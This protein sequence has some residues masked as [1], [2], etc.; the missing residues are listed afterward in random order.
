MPKVTLNRL[1]TLSPS[2]IGS[3]NTNSE[4]LETALEN[5]LSRDG[6]TPNEMEADLD[7]NSN[8]ILNARAIITEAVGATLIET[9]RCYVNEIAIHDLI[10]DTTDLEN[11][12]TALEEW[13]DEEEGRGVS[14]D[15]RIDDLES[16]QT[17][18]N[19]HLLSLDAADVSHEAS[20]ASLNSGQTTQNSRLTA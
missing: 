1:A 2:V 5:T 11:R 7:M 15:A 10:T 20:I 17:V 16:S 19:S 3:V 18:Q 9:Q 13:T 4:R 8:D 14:M 12:V 6:T